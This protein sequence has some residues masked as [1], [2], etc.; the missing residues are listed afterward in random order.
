MTSGFMLRVKGQH[1]SWLGGLLSVRA[2]NTNDS[3]WCVIFIAKDQTKFCFNKESYKIM[4]CWEGKGQ[5]CSWLGGSVPAIPSFELRTIGNNASCERIIV[6][7]PSHAN[8]IPTSP[9]FSNPSI[10][11]GYN[12]KTWGYLLH[13]YSLKPIIYT[14][15]SNRCRLHN[16]TDRLHLLVDRCHSLHDTTD[17]SLFDF[18]VFGVLEILIEPTTPSVIHWAWN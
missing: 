7:N 17:R 6:N 14:R 18:S 4:F 12:T 9:A 13:P 2:I 10:H 3:W 16:T 5:H 15:P 1:R 11:S 8:T